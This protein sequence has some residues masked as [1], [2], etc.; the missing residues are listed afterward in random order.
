MNSYGKIVRSPTFNFD[1]SVFCSK[2]FQCDSSSPRHQH[3]QSHHQHPRKGNQLH[4]KCAAR[5]GSPGFTHPKK[6][7]GPPLESNF[8]QWWIRIFRFLSIPQKKKTTSPFWNAQKD[9]LIFYK[10][11]S[12]AILESWR[13]KG[14]NFPSNLPGFFGVE[15]NIATF[16]REDLGWGLIL[17]TSAFSTS[18]IHR[19]NPEKPTVF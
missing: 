8:T 17:P 7:G 10:N 4:R 1:L 12:L 2:I 3:V 18:K 14:S 19:Y 11:I 16:G 13:Y 9:S 5:R 15:I 6:M